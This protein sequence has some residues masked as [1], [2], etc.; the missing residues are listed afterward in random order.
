M[1]WARD[2]EHV[3]AHGREHH[4]DGRRVVGVLDVRHGRVCG[5]GVRGHVSG[6]G[7]HGVPA[8]P[9]AAHRGAPQDRSLTTAGGAERFRVN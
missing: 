9:A 2:A 3:K 4:D 7:D 5:G 1:C 8:A 6:A